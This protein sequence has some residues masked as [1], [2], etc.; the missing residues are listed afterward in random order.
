MSVTRSGTV[1]TAPPARTGGARRQNYAR[2][3]W[4]FIAPAGVV[5]AA[6]IVFPWIYTLYMSLQDWRVGG[7]HS[8]AG[9]ANYQR[10]LT[11]GRLHDAVWRTFYFTV[12]AV[13]GP[14]VLGVAAAVCFHQQFPLRG[15]ARTIFVLPMMATPV[16]VALVWTMMFHPQLGVLNYLLS[17]IGIPPAAW[18]YDADT[19]IPTLAMV[20]TWQWTPLVMLVVLG[21]L[22]SLPQDPYEAAR[23][24]GATS[25]QMF[26]HI[27]LPLVWPFIMVATVIRAI[28]ALKAFDLIFVITQ[29]GPGTASETINILL[30]LQAFA[31]YD[32]GFASA[33]VVVFFVLIMAITLVLL[34]TRQKAALS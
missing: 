29:G 22:A 5:V 26:R 2:H 23:L 8:F 31:Y 24:D 7:E 4:A 17:L 13:I 11:E 21:G 25:W 30:Y 3:Y 16:A 15:L 19:V 6:I 18:V 34:R 10:L 14:V 27:T 32:I 33:I 1:T 20:E 9:L 12:L 28:D